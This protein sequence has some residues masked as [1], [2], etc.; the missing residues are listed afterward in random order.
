MSSFLIP[1][2]KP[3]NLRFWNFRWTIKTLFFCSD[4]F[5]SNIQFFYAKTKFETFT[6]CVF[7][8]VFIFLKFMAAKL[9][10]WLKWPTTS[11]AFDDETQHAKCTNDDSH[12]QRYKN[13]I[14][15]CFFSQLRGERGGDRKYITLNHHLSRFW[16]RKFASARSSH[17]HHF[18][19][20]LRKN[21]KPLKLVQSLIQ[22]SQNI[23]VPDF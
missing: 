2:L 16:A 17:L 14:F 5:Q 18:V 20:P 15:L 21:L 19:H 10:L 9:P 11:N 3:S 8:H 4:N 1:R 6:F 22:I 7:L 23:F 13:A 12:H